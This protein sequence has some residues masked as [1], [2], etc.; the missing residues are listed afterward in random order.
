MSLKNYFDNELNKMLA[1][2]E[3]NKNFILV[4]GIVQDIAKKLI[5][6]F[7]YCNNVYDNETYVS[8]EFSY[9]L[10]QVICNEIVYFS[11]TEALA[12][13]TELGKKVDFIITP[14]NTLYVIKN[15]Q[16]YLKSF[17]Y[18]LF[19]FNFFSNY[20]KNKGEKNNEK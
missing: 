2:V 14:K 19:E 18:D 17:L 11:Y 5:R 6:L 1:S 10:P 16:E 9:R 20:F 15:A 13:L 8:D 4:K 7:D 3:E 12:L